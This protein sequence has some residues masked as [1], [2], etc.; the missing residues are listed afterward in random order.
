MAIK[1]YQ[2]VYHAGYGGSKHAGCYENFEKRKKHKPLG[3]CFSACRKSS[4][5]P[6]AS[7]LLCRC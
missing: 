5:I 7:R 2:I 4:E 6:N 3:E 1:D